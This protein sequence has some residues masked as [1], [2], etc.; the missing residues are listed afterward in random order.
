MTKFARDCLLK[1][2]Q[3]TRNLVESL[4]A[5]TAELDMRF[6][7]HSGTVTGGVLRGQKSRFQLFGD[8]MN[9]AGKFTQSIDSYPRLVD[10]LETNSFLLSLQFSPNGIQRYE[11]Q[12]PHLPNHG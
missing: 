1:T 5:E 4:G 8:T 11:R 12:D 2:H 9:T 7:L 6:G 3:V 10:L